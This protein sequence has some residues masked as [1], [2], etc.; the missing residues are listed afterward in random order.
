MTGKK[1]TLLVV[2]VVVLLAVPV[3]AVAADRFTDVPST[4]IFH[5]DIAWLADAGITVGCNPPLNDEFCPEEPVKR[6][7]MAAFMRRFAQHL[8]PVAAGA[9]WDVDATGGFLVEETIAEVTIVAP[10]DGVL[11]M[12]ATGDSW[13]GT[14]DIWCGFELDGGGAGFQPGLHRGYVDH[15]QHNEADC[16]TSGIAEVDAGDHTV[17]LVYS[18]DSVYIGQMSAVWYPH[19]S[20]SITVPAASAGFGK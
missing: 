14:G 11:V 20:V 17:A 3:V 7:Q 13:D 4:N 9:N 15:S 2:T 8:L 19:G 12:S 6:Q 5:D 1:R 10:T 16:V 18:G